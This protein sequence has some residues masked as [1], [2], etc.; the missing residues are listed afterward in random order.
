VTLMRHLL[1]VRIDSA[2]FGFDALDVEEILTVSSCVSLPVAGQ[3]AVGVLRWRGQA[4]AVVDIG[5]GAATPSPGT[6]RSRVV[7]VRVAGGPIAV[8]V[9]AVQEV[10]ERSDADP[11]M[12]DIPAVLRAIAGHEAPAAHTRDREAFHADAPPGRPGGDVNLVTISS[13][14]FD[15]A[16]L[17]DVVR[18]IVS[19]R[20]W[21]GPEPFDFAEIARVP[22]PGATAQ[23]RLVVVSAAGRELVLRVAGA[24]S[25]RQLEAS[26]LLPLPPLSRGRA[27]GDLFDRIAFFDDQPP[28][29]LLNP[30]AFP[31]ASA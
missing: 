4:V 30:A 22:R 2:W 29:L 21:T 13:E 14:G 17:T 28:L 18:A 31:A 3:G 20:D 7:V 16:L 11:P 27:S 5:S 12:I 23:E 10:R 24:V 9:T 1:P 6:M 26:Q 15:Y 19:P 8:Q 25:F